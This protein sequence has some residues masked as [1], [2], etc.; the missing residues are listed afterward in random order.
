MAGSP[1]LF[2]LG[3]LSVQERLGGSLQW[4]PLVAKQQL[5]ASDVMRVRTTVARFPSA[6][7]QFL[8]SDE[9]HTLVVARIDG[10]KATVPLDTEAQNIVSG[11]PRPHDVGIRISGLPYLEATLTSKLRRDQWRLLGL[12]VLVS[13]IVLG[14]AFARVRWITIPFA[15]AGLGILM[16]LGALGWLDQP[17]TLLTSILPPLLLTVG[18]SDA[19]HIVLRHRE[20]L[21]HGGGDAVAMSRR[22]M[23]RAC[24]ATSLTT[25][26][27]FATLGMST[28]PS[29]RLFA[30]VATAGI[31]V[32]YFTV[33]LVSR[34]GLDTQADRAPARSALPWIEDALAS[35]CAWTLAHRRAV[36]VFAA[37]ATLL[38]IGAAR[39]VSFN[40][41]LLDQFLPQDDEAK[42][43]QIIDRSLGGLHTLSVQLSSAYDPDPT[44]ILSRARALERDISA[45]D[46]V[47]HIRSP[48]RYIEDVWATLSGTPRA[49]VWKDSGRF[50]ALDK[51]LHEVA[52]GTFRRMS[53]RDLVR[54]DV[55]IGDVGTDRLRQLMTSIRGQAQRHGLAAQ[56]SG[57]ASQTTLQLAIVVKEL[58]YSCLGAV[59]VIFALI[60]LFLRDVRLALISVPLNLFPMTCTAAYMALSGL[61]VGPSAL[62]VFPIALGIAVDGTIHLL[63]RC[64]HEVRRYDVDT[65]ITHSLKH[66][67]SA[68]VVATTTLLAGFAMLHQSLFRPIQLFAELAVVALT[69]SL[70]AELLFLPPLAR[71]AL[72]HRSHRQEKR[73]GWDSNPR[74]GINRTDA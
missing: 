33:I 40:S 60:A 46:S 5:R 48:T 62:I 18:L 37:T 11:I 27:G 32:S 67:G 73:R 45:L 63:I 29:L 36:L 57:S 7:K 2:P 22:Q 53:D 51:L 28:V 69:T 74:Y 20:A 31:V 72:V 55:G 66:T 24:L 1:Q 42:T 44:S 50:H 68:V 54:L 14:L 58:L 47:R 12:T 30:W 65:A 26:A 21:T 34:S 39:H 64:R 10:D 41:R 59:V 49:Q 35:V 61:A 9:R 56:L 6:A 43:A 19:V 70:A 16:T 38:A 17:L 13:T 25:A 8:S 71:A 3:M 4:G 52:G 15:G 23:A